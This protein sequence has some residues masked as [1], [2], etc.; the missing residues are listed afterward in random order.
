[1]KKTFLVA[2][3]AALIVVFAAVPAAAQSGVCRQAELLAQEYFAARGEYSGTRSGWNRAWETGRDAGLGALITRGTTSD[4]RTIAQ[5]A[6]YVGG[7][8]VI[9][10]E[11]TGWRSRKGLDRLRTDMLAAQAACDRQGQGREREQQEW[12]GAQKDELREELKA[13]REKIG[14]LQQQ[15]QPPPPPAHHQTQTVENCFERTIVAVRSDSE[16]KILHPGQRAEVTGQPEFWSWTGSEWMNLEQ[17]FIHPAA[18][19]WKIY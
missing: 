12:Q 14:R 18:S 17:K 4:W 2:V 15:S 10:Q 5:V 1:M 9:K 19:G 7:G 11:I 16:E 13:L 3:L 8:S 6:G